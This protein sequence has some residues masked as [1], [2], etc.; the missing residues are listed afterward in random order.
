MLGICSNKHSCWPRMHPKSRLSRN[1]TCPWRHGSV[2]HNQRRLQWRQFM[3]IM[4]LPQ[5]IGNCEWHLHPITICRTFI[6]QF[7]IEWSMSWQ[8]SARRIPTQQNLCVWLCYVHRS[9]WNQKRIVW[10][11]TSAS[12]IYCLKRLLL[13]KIWCLKANLQPESRR[14]RCRSCRM[15]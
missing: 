7:Y 12:R 4:D 5:G 6:R 10:K 11:W 3:E 14:T 15:E 9:V 1:R 8:V 2:Q 13:I